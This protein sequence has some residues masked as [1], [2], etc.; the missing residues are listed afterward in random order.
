MTNLD[1]PLTLDEMVAAPCIAELQQA[2]QDKGEKHATERKF[3]HAVKRDYSALYQEE[4]SQAMIREASEEIPF[5]EVIVDDQRY[6]LFGVL[7]P[8]FVHLTELGNNVK[9]E[10]YKSDFFF[11]EQELPRVFSPRSNFKYENIIEMADHQYKPHLIDFRFGLKVGALLPYSLPINLIKGISTSFYYMVT[12][13]STIDYIEKITNNPKYKQ[14]LKEFFNMPLDSGYYKEMPVN[15]DLELRSK[16]GKYNSLQRRSAYMAEFMR[17]CNHLEAEK[18]AIVGAKHVSEM[19]YFLLNGYPE[20]DVVMKAHD[21]A[22]LF[23]DNKEA[24]Q[25]IAISSKRSRAIKQSLGG[26]FTG[27][28]LDAGIVYALCQLF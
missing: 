25:E 4:L 24:Y 26:V 19:K 8:L 13:A 16:F 27:L 7:H 5:S 17:A 23:M 10:I 28:A 18:K 22:Q 15:V 14:Q 11:L 9:K 6:K 1:V 20:Q 21:D 12:G 2:Y 3:L